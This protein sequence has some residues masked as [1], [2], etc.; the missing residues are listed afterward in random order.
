LL[1]EALLTVRFYLPRRL[2]LSEEQP[3]SSVQEALAATGLDFV[4]YS[5]HIFRIG[6]ASTAARSGLDDSTV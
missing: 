5:G 4:G 1:A 2:P 6:A 3:V